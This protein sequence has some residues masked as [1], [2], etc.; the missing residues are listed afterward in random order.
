VPPTSPPGVT[1]LEARSH[2]SPDEVRSLNKSR[3]EVVRLEGFTLGRFKFEPGWRWSECIKPVAKTDLCQVSHVGYA[4][5]GRTTVR[6][7]DGTEKTIAAGESYTIPPGH[8][9]WVEG[10]EAFVGIEVMSAE[11]Y[12]KASEDLLREIAEALHDVVLLSDE[13]RTQ[14]LF[15]NAAYEQ[16]WGRPREELYV[17]P[18]ALLEGVH[19]EDRERVRDAIVSQSRG[20]YDLEF[21]V[22][23]P[24]GGQRWVWSRGFPVRNAS[25]EI[26]RSASITEDITDRKQIIESHEQLIRGFTHD[27]K[28]PLGA[29]DGYLSLLELGVRGEMSPAQMETVGRARRS[30]RTALDLVAQLLEI[31]RAEA[32][33]LDIERG[34]MDLAA[35]TREIVEEFR[36]AANAKRL[37]LAPLVL[38]D[39]GIESLVI[40]SDRARVRQIFANL[41]S[42]AV[43]YTQPDGSIE[44]KVHLVDDGEGPRR[45]RWVALSVADNGPGIPLEKQNMIFRE[46]TRFDPGAVEGSGI[47]LAISQR[48]AR[49]LGAV[50]T[51]K[52]AP[53]VGSTFTLWL[54]ND[55][56]PSLPFAQEPG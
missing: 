56:S 30:I 16:I 49:A 40:E 32:G 11:H 41:I 17:N 15:V 36:F 51:C 27:V 13:S 23:R 52:S 10:N 46:F 53:G 37:S 55:L 9:G 20:E 5:S 54:P 21:R 33:Q 7:E 47:G 29:A 25:G 24:D 28:N 1:K 6:M 50:I 43:K 31:E 14:L 12:A 38:G 8:D 3:I 35:T 39:H 42:N 2:G 22:V 18:I 26:Y 45:G 4:V 48:L 34:R 19:P 44:V